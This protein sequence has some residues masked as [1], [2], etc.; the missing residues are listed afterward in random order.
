MG[1]TLLINSSIGEVRAA[2]LENDLPTHITLL[3]AHEP[4][5]L[6]SQSSAQ[7][8]KLAPELDGAFIKLN[9]QNIE[10]FL[11]RRGVLKA[12][13]QKQSPINGLVVEGQV[14]NVEITRDPMPQDNKLAIAKEIIELSKPDQSHFIHALLSK[15]GYGDIDEIITDDLATLTQLKKQLDQN[16]I[17]LT[18]YSSKEPLFEYYG[19]NDKL[20][21]VIDN[22]ISL[23]SGGWL[24]IEHTKALTAID[25]NSSNLAGQIKLAGDNALKTNLEA[26]NAI[27]HALVFQNIGGLIV[28]DFID[29]AGKKAK[30]NLQEQL[31]IALKAD[32]LHVEIGKLSPFGLLEIKRQKSGESL[33]ERLMVNTPRP[34]ADALG[35]EL[36]RQAQKQGAMPN[37]GDVEITAP[38]DVIIW[39]KNNTKACNE[40]KE[41]T[42]R[43][44]VFK[45]D[46]S[47]TGIVSIKNPKGKT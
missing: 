11:P 29:M 46:D 31:E 7:V 34:R 12:K 6:G 43:N 23:P 2:V 10:A 21:Q 25:V 41:N 22:N 3:R 36:L 39:L 26:A 15:K 4:S 16:H 28:V 47:S 5:F 42:A 27:A 8:I 33:K 13:Q 30:Q 14:I 45:T 24:S 38:A 19:V 20:E 37:I 40:L 32:P 44:L 35:L 1:K 9:N 17:T 18:A